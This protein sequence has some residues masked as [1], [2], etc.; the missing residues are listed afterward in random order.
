[1]NDHDQ[2]ADR[3]STAEYSLDDDQANEVIRSCLLSQ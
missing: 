2:S 3:P 1:M